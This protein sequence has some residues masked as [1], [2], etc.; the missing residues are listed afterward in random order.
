MAII[1]TEARAH[2]PPVG[3]PTTSTVAGLR[4]LE[5]H[6][7]G[8]RC[9]VQHD[10][11][12][13]TV[14]RAFEQDV[15]QWV[16]AFEARYSRFRPDSIVSQINRAAGGDWVE[17]DAATE[18][19]LDICQSVHFMTGG[20]V[21]S[22]AGCLAQLWDYHNP[23]KQLPSDAT[24][25]ELL[26]RVGW[27]RIERQPG[28]VRLPRAGMAIDFG[29][30]GK[31]F[32]VDQ[33]IGLAQQHGLGAVMVDFGHDIRTLGVPP[34]RPAWHVGLEDPKSPGT[35]R[36]S[37][38]VAGQAVA[39]SGDYLRGFTI[40][41][42]RYGHIIDPRNGRPVSN[43]CR[44]V[45]VVAPTCLQAGL[46]STAAFILGPRPGMERIEDTMGAEGI[47]VTDAGTHQSRGFFNYVVT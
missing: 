14:A 40:E 18:Q 21:D 4:R 39:S 32:S 47:I 19:C 44:Q 12:G 29:G 17:I 37:I 28:R 35:L 46:L 8:T 1:Q 9:F 34:D 10:A 13:D 45:T 31:E 26:G 7:M 11:P 33:V 16:Q 2:L 23:P 25:A 43:G 20:M 6:A 24:V 27:S 5:F 22:T 3:L 36:G 42:R 38:A 15:L 41:G 30:W